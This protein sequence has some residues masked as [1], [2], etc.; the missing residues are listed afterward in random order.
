MAVYRQAVG[1]LVGILQ[2]PKTDEKLRI[3]KDLVYVHNEVFVSLPIAKSEAQSKTLHH[4]INHSVF[5]PTIYSP[6][7]RSYELLGF[8]EWMRPY[9]VVTRFE[10]GVRKRKIS[11]AKYIA[12]SYDMITGVAI[13]R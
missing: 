2:N 11:I 12:L 5:K 4:H 7:E 10:N 13:P 6:D 1:E 3:K 8:P 9:I